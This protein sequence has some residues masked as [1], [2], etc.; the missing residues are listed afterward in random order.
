METRL[1]EY[2]ST[3][4]KLWR[5]STIGRREMVA[6]NKRPQRN[7]EEG[8]VRSGAKEG[9]HQTLWP[10]QF[11]S[12]RPASRMRVD[13]WRYSMTS[14]HREVQEGDETESRRHCQ[15]GRMREASKGSARTG[16]NREGTRVGSSDGAHG[17]TQ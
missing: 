6:R 1:M 15:G 4:A 9:V 10:I 7:H 5:R 14:T 8:G 17:R 3:P 13:A 11:R 2:G 12:H 16:Q